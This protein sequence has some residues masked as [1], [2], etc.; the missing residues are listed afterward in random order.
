MAKR[1]LAAELLRE[2]GQ[3]RSR[4][5]SGEELSARMG[6][7]RTAVWKAACRL[8]EQGCAIESVTRLG[9]RLSALP[10]GMTH[11]L[12]EQYLPQ[13]RGET[14][15]CYE[16]TDSTNTRGMQLSLEGAPT[17]TVVTADRQTHGS[18]RLG[19]SFLSPGGQGVYLS[20]LLR[21][22]CDPAALSLLT[23]CAGLAV[24][25]VL[26]RHGL[27]PAIKWPNDIILDRRKVCGILTKLT[28]DAE[29]GTVNGAVIGI[30][31]NVTQQRQDFP[32]E[33]RDKAVSLREAGVTVP[34]AALAADIITH[35]DE[36]FLRQHILSRPSAALIEELTRRSCTVGSRVE[37]ISP[38]D[39]Y[40]AL[41]VGI[42]PDAGLIVELPDGSR[43]TVSSGEV[44]VRGLLGYT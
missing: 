4:Y 39:S 43:R 21:P 7:S 30:G 5:H 16:E 10:D 35:L 38:T 13:G 28:S 41:A 1:D 20:Y 9:Y 29:S 24:C 25:Q 17:G 6:V 33:L 31:V 32:E 40:G 12:L 15:I 36:M 26:E 42:A 27:T 44:S 19:R 34:R 18:G 2:L 22:D 14:V 37:V 23:S 3:D 8:R 11:E